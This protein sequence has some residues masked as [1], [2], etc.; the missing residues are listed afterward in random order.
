MELLR[1]SVAARRVGLHPDTLRVWADAG[2]VPVVWV[3]RERRFPSQALEALVEGNGGQARER[4][5]ALYVRVSGRT[6]QESSLAAQ[7]AELRASTAGEVVAVFRDRASGLRE[8]RPG[9]DRLLRRA[10]NGE[11]THVRVTHEDRLARFGAAWITALLARDQVRVEVLHPKA[12]APGGS[13]ELLADFRSL[14]ASFSGR[15]YGIRS[16]QARR[17]L[18][19]AAAAPSAQGAADSE[20]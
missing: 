14:V 7:E 19:Q 16:R 17:R 13:E 9:L 10:Q 5:E 2:K 4:R 8:S 15:L 11:F 20:A 3:G 12:G 6:G 18:L 1:L